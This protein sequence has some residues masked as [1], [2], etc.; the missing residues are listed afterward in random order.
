[1]MRK[2]EGDVEL[3]SLVVSGEVGGL[4]ERSEKRSD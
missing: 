1:M 3:A 4:Y 2:K